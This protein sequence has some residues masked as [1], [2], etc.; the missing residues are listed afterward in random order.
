M[1]ACRSAQ[2]HGPSPTQSLL[3]L[4]L[5]A[6][7]HASG[8]NGYLASLPALLQVS[9]ALLVGIGTSFFSTRLLVEALSLTCVTVAC[10][11]IIVAS[12]SLDFTQA[13]LTGRPSSLFYDYRHALT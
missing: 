7:G 4:S 8:L 2:L 13:G 1:K 3:H 11:F 6:P 9:F 5:Q 12:T 10:I